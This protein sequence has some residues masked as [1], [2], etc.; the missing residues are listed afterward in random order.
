MKALFLGHFAATVAPRILAKV[1]TP[2]E[3]SLLDDEGDAA[4]LAPLLADA[5]IVVGHIWRA[6]FPP[7]PRLRLLQS[8]A[9]ARAC[10]RE[11][12]GTRRYSQISRRWSKPTTRGDPES[13]LRWN[14]QEGAPAGAGAAGAGPP[15]EPHPGG[16][17][18][19]CGGL[20][21][22]SQPQDQGGRQPPR[23]GCAV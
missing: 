22:A 17:T 23:P 20:Q 8:V 21:P 1:K 19:Q 3:T 16:L 14:L 9:A 6:G 7:A 10:P 18:A 12:G 11:G 4:L 13:P 15:S 5:E 2:L